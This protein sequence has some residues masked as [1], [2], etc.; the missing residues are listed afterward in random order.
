MIPGFANDVYVCME[1]LGI[2][3]KVDVA[4]GN[5]ETWFDVYDAI[6]TVTNRTMDNLGTFPHSGL[7]GM[8]FHESFDTNGLFYTSHL[9][10]HPTDTSG[11][12]YLAEDPNAVADSVVVEWMYDA[13]QVDPSSYRQLLRIAMPTFPEEDTA[14]ASPI[15]QIAMHEG[16]LYIM[17]GDGVIETVDVEGGRGNNVFGKAL[18]ITPDGSEDFEY[19]IPPSNPFVG[20]DRFPDEVYAVGFRNP[21]TICFTKDG[22]ALISDIG[23]DNAEEVNMLMSGADYGWNQREGTF[24]HVK[25]GGG[26]VLGVG[27]DLPEDDAL[28]GFTYPVAQFGHEGGEEGAGYQATLSQSIAGG[29]PVEVDGAPLNGRYF[30]GDFPA[31]GPVYYSYLSDLRSAVTQ[32]SNLTQA[33]TYLATL[34]LY[35]A[36][37]DLV[38]STIHFRDIVQYGALEKGLSEPTR[39]DMRFGLTPDGALL[40][41]SKRDGNI[42]IVTNSIAS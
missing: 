36:T 40:I 1:S 7:R 28:N 34:E 14:Y 27:I 31:N 30:Y 23:R 8:A 26:L 13:G 41:S 18:R 24:V 9:E 29:F 35:N 11:L 37:D 2:I 42:Y 3:R 22:E 15:K 6:E 33:T 20:D 10:S 16:D 32:G 25:S 39:N 4:T 17:M 21:H 12:T 38:L 19:T 5:V